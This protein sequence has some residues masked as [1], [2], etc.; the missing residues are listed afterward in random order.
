MLTLQWYTSSM[1]TARWVT[2]HTIW[3]S[4]QTI[5]KCFQYV[6]SRESWCRLA[7]TLTRYIFMWLLMR[8]V[9]HRVYGNQR[10]TLYELQDSIRTTIL[11]IPVDM[12]RKKT[13]SQVTCR[14]LFANW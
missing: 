8:S 13:D 5:E 9:K 4:M 2:S 7:F 10:H 11:Q 6:S 1:V 12:L 3:I 14:G